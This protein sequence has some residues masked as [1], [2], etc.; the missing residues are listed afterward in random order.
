VK[1]WLQLHIHV[2]TQFGG[3]CPDLVHDFKGFTVSEDV[4]KM[5]EE[6]VRLG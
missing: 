1:L 6:T 3:V 4:N 2:A 5:K